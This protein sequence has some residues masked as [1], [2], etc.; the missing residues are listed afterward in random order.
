M[1]LSTRY[2]YLT[3]LGFIYDLPSQ[4]RAA[5]DNNE[6]AKA[7]VCWKEASTLLSHYSHLPA[8]KHI[9]DESRD[10]MQA[11]ARK[12]QLRIIDQNVL[13]IDIGG[14]RRRD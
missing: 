14:A 8:F 2:Q 11:F 4:I 6:Y 5:I 9:E 7:L 10:L 1:A 3:K 13:E 12:A